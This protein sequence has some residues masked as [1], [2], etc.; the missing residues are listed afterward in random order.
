MEAPAKTIGTFGQAP[1]ERRM[2]CIASRGLSSICAGTA[3]R[4]VGYNASLDCQ[5]L[6]TDCGGGRVGARP[7]S[8]RGERPMDRRENAA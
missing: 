5:Q 2:F 8:T 6:V 4:T 3:A 7:C 1:R